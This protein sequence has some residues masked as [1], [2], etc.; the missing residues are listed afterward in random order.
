[1]LIAPSRRPAPRRRS[2]GSRCSGRGCRTAPRGSRPRSGSGTRAS[3]S[4]VATTSPG[5]QKPHWTAPASTNASWTRWSSP[6]G[7]PL[8]RHDLVPVRLRGEH[9]ARA[10][11]RAVQQHGA[12][13]ALALLARVLRPGQPEP[14]AEREEQA[15]AGPDVRLAP[16]AVDGQLDPHARHRSSARACEHAQ[17][18]P[19]VRGRAAHVVDRARAPP[20]RARR[21][22]S[23]SSSG[24]ATSPATGPAEPNDARSSPRSRSATTASEQT[25]ITIAFRGPTFMNVCGAPRRLDPHGRDQLVGLERVPLRPDEELAERQRPDA[26]HARQLDRR[27]PRRAA[28]AARRRPARRCR[29]CRRSCRGCGSAA[30]RPSATPRPAPGSVLGERRLHR[31]GVGEPRAQPQR[32]VLRATSREAPRPRSG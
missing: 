22:T 32:A 25:A 1:M 21:T 27:A 15:L 14:L 26:A 2:S 8:D 7:E 16:L 4:A 30:S 9:E 24:D 12:R 31:L 20:R 19:A 23:A 11:E 10:D 17:R 3:R 29:G 28:A 5:V 6:S 13:A 18:V